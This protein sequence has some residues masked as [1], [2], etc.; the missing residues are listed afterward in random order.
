MVLTQLEPSACCLPLLFSSVPQCSKGK[1]RALV[2]QRA[3]SRPDQA[4]GPRCGRHSCVRQ[5]QM[6]LK[7]TW[8]LSKVLLEDWRERQWMQRQ[9][10]TPA[11]VAAQNS[12]QGGTW[13]SAFL[14][15]AQAALLTPG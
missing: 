14:F 8:G 2:S 12:H 1:S 11:R 13:G 9:S 5:V 4:S 7:F 10:L 6:A 3:E 15:P